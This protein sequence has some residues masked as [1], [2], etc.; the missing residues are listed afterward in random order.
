MRY[1]VAIDRATGGLPALKAHLR[2][3]AARWNVYD[4]PGVGGE[5]QVVAVDRSWAVRLVAVRAEVV[6][7]RMLAAYGEL[8]RAPFPAHSAY[9]VEVEVLEPSTGS[10]FEALVTELL[11]RAAWM[12][13]GLDAFRPAGRVLQRLAL[14]ER[15]EHMFS[16]RDP[17]S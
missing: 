9:V 16:A 1:F 17:W 5:L 12:G 10:T 2:Q 14:G 11:A 4:V 15:L 13:P 6:R 8:R 3:R 7:A